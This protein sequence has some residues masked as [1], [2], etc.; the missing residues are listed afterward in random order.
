VYR[1][2]AHDRLH[3]LGVGTPSTWLFPGP[4]HSSPLTA[5]RLCECLRTLGIQAQSGHRA[6]LTS[7]A[8]QLPPPDEPSSCDLGRARWTSSRDGSPSA[9]PAASSA[10]T[11]RLSRKSCSLMFE[12]ILAG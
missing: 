6:T 5:A 9:S 11:P 4:L 1:E 3:Y 2:A 7:L 10:A 12:R 8:A